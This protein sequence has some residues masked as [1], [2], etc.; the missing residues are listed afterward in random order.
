MG[1]AETDGFAVVLA[2]EDGL[3]DAVGFAVAVGFV[4]A[5][6]FVVDEG[7]GDFVAA[8]AVLPDNAKAIARKRESLLNRAPI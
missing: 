6:A 4:V 1:F 8:C 7:L 2:V 3:A 5:V